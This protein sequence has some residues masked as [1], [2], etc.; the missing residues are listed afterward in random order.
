M[1]EG[2]PLE[3]T[4][5]W[6]P[7]PAYRA[8]SHG[9]EELADVPKSKAV[10]K[11]DGLLLESLKAV[12]GLRTGVTCQGQGRGLQDP[13]SPHPAMDAGNVLETPV[14]RE[15]GSVEMLMESPLT[16]RSR[17]PWQGSGSGGLV[18]KPL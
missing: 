5:F 14:R 3:G 16:L 17:P 10:M 11:G 15:A 8:T 6:V 12:L 18:R 9:K 7:S 4:A 2:L 13:S 1:S